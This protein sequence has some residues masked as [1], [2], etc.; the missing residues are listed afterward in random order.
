MA[1]LPTLRAAEIEIRH[2]SPESSL[3]PIRSWSKKVTHGGR[4]LLRGRTI[5]EP[6]GFSVEKIRIAFR[7]A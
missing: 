5:S 4:A 7:V 1:T 6:L 3:D 2:G